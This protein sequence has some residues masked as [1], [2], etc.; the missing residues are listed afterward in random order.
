M[1]RIALYYSVY[2]PQTLQSQSFVSS[3]KCVLYPILNRGLLVYMSPQDLDQLMQLILH[4]LWTYMSLLI[5]FH[6]CTEW[7]NNTGAEGFE[8]W[9][10]LWYWKLCCVQAWMHRLERWWSYC[11]IPKQGNCWTVVCKVCDDPTVRIWVCWSWG[12]LVT[13]NCLWLVSMLPVRGFCNFS[14]SMS[15]L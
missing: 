12:M 1:G 15:C 14:L 10:K 4:A 7:K 8:E 9:V 3:W 11:Y 5:S 13:Y 2:S 6:A